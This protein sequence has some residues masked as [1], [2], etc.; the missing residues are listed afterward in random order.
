MPFE[1]SQKSRRQGRRILS[2]ATFSDRVSLGERTGCRCVPECR[3]RGRPL[4]ATMAAVEHLPHGYTNLTR[5][6]ADRIEKRFE[7]A[8]AITRAKREFAGLTGLHGRYPVP[9]V[10]EFDPS[11]PSLLLREV[12]GRHGQ[13]L[14]EQGHSAVVLRVTGTQLA[15]LQ[16][17]DPAVVPGLEGTGDVIVHGDFGPQNI[18]YSVDASDVAGVVDWEMAHIGSPIEDLAWS[19]W[20]I[21]MHHPDAHD[22]LSELFAASGLK[23]D[24]SDRQDWMLRQC[25]DYLDYCEASEF[26]EGVAEWKRRLD[27]TGRW[28]E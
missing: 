24:W 21:R 16:V 11:A 10:L 5:R 2:L 3:L 8:D 1:A 6:L 25:R 7:G 9:E 14:I 12:V 20:I 26:D 13:E 4:L 28:Q 27:V 22:D 15:K 23:F 19:E 17:I 18:L